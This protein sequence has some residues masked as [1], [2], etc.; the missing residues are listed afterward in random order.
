MTLDEYKMFFHNTFRFWFRDCVVRDRNAFVFITE[1]QLTDE[2]LEE[3]ESGG[4]LNGR[5]P[6][7]WI[8]P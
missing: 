7:F 5:K 3:E 6:L 2:Q 1:P 4:Y 8:S